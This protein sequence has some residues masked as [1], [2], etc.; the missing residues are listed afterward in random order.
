LV[1]L[2]WAIERMGT[3]AL[4]YFGVHLMG[5]KPGI[6]KNYHYFVYHQQFQHTFHIPLY[7]YFL[8]FFI[9]KVN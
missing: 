6:C 7:F 1:F 9:F 5:V 8:F 3:W 2:K 4:F